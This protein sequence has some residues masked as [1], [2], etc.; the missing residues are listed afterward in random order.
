MPRSEG[1]KAKLIRLLQILA[2]KTDENHL[3]AVNRLVEELEKFGIT[4]ERKSI[5]ADI[6]AL[7]ELG[8][9]VM[10]QRGRGG[11]YWLAGRTF[12]LAE[13]K[14]LAD[15][16]QAS[17]FITP[18]KS[19]Q[20]IR[21]LS[22]FA[23]DWQADDLKRQVF[24]SAR[25]KSM[26]ESI[27][28][29]V[30]ALH[31]AIA[32]NKQ[33]QFY[34][35]KGNKR[36]QRAFSPDELRFVSP[37]ALLFEEDNYYLVAYEEEKGL[38]HYRVDKMERLRTIDLP[39][40]GSQVYDPNKMRDYA[41]PMFGMFRGPVEHICLECEGAVIGSMQDRFGNEVTA[42]ADENGDYR[43]Y[44][45]VAVSPPFFGWV[46]SF[47]GRVRI[48]QPAHV[49]QQFEAHLEAVLKKSKGE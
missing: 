12:E 29:T 18:K 38:R 4:A 3:L 16:V 31:T 40:L 9:D 34:Y 48:A 32:E 47:G 43:I 1:Q 19:E 10:Q 27:Y 37:W 24:A 15:S 5:Y 33:V 36:R 2:A 46:A 13:L 35:R 45:D 44:A 14:L 39:R 6:E 30:D 22:R 17:R 28:Y 25:V 49:K 26:N 41:K 23:S 8:F 21:K 20:L 11:G 7:R 42:L